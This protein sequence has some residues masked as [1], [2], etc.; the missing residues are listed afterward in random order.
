MIENLRS[1]ASPAEAG[2]GELSQPVGISS[3]SIGSLVL[4]QLIASKLSHGVIGERTDGI[5]TSTHAIEL[6]PFPHAQDDD[7][8]ARLASEREERESVERIRDQHRRDSEERKQ[9]EQNN[10]E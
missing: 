2:M 5:P 7:V 9:K 8:A 1:I 4:P 3:R 10:K 6:Q